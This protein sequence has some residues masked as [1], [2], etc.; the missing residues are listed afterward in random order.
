LIPRV[1]IKI[2]IIIVLIFNCVIPYISDVYLT[3]CYKYHDDDDD[4]DDN[5]SMMMNI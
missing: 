3:A 1:K 2:I 4:D 5:E